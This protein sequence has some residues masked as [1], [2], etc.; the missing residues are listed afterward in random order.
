[1][2]SKRSPL[3]KFLAGIY[4]ITIVF[5][6]VNSRMCGILW[7]GVL[8]KWFTMP[9]VSLMNTLGWEVSLFGPLW[10]AMLV[11]TIASLVNAYILYFIIRIFSR[12]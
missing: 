5:L 12:K 1:M 9:W 8:L 11:T 3:G 6:F 10:P 7:C 4:L 2:K